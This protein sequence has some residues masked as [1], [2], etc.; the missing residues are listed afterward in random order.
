MNFNHQSV[1][2]NEAV[3]G[4]FTTA[5]GIYVDCTLGGAGHS[6]AIAQRLDAT[7]K[8][9]GIDQDA[10]AIATA[11]SRLANA[12]LA[13]SYE[14]VR[15][16]F[17]KL[18]TIIKGQVDGIIFDLG[19]SSYQIDTAERGFSYIKDAPLDMRMN[20]DADFS[21]LNVVNEYSQEELT[22]IFLDY[23]E[24]RWSKRIAEF[25]VKARSTE[26]IKT[27]AELVKIINQAIPKA[28]REHQHP[29]KRIFQAIRIEVNQEL[30]ILENAFTTAIASLKPG[31]RLAIITFHSL[32]DRIA[33]NV[34]KKASLDCICPPK[35][36]IC[37]CQHKRQ[38]KLLKVIKPTAA[39]VA[40][41]SRAKSAKLRIAIKL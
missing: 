24:E 22:R 39:E 40:A 9:I 15:S 36:P 33:K 1:L 3:D 32:E 35:Q 2:L 20:Q 10:A 41:N 23:G 38:V 13:C 30:E 12:N 17:S 21:A 14:V 6:L 26:P 18:A 11:T 19:V 25:I 7:G 8:V 31:G 5:S 34:L 37:T 29:E 4:V 27:T 16:N 28:A